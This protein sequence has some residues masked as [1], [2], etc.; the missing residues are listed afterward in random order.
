MFWS[1]DVVMMF[2]GARSKLLSLRPLIRFS[3]TILGNERP[4]AVKNCWR[5][6]ILRVSAFCLGGEQI[7][8]FFLKVTKF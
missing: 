6:V 8:Q 5:I 3:K 4:Q 2:I 7:F 1:N